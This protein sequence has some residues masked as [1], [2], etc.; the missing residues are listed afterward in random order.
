MFIVLKTGVIFGN[1][2]T[3]KKIVIQSVDK[4]ITIG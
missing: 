1:K 2:Y 3:I 4:P